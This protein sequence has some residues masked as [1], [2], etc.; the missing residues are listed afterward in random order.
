[1]R[2]GESKPRELRDVIVREVKII[3]YERNSNWVL[4]HE[5][6]K[7]KIYQIALLGSIT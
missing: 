1:L 6:S 5:M 4:D 2:G 7:K 3:K